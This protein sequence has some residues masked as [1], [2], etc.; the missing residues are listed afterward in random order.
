M[1]VS[2][3]KMEILIQNG[4][5]R[6]RASPES[7]VSL[8]EVHGRLQSD[9]FIQAITKHW[10]DTPTPH[11]VWDLKFAQLSELDAASCHRIATAANGL[12]KFR[13]KHPQSVFVT[14]DNSEYWLLRF[15][16]ELMESRNSPISYRIVHTME[17]AT[18]YLLE[19]GAIVENSFIHT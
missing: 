19:H 13:G 8:F 5:I 6:S 7:G 9:A 16:I 11:A 4:S 17:M 2:G 18:R 1:E 14:R 12:A 10:T 3:G 15:F